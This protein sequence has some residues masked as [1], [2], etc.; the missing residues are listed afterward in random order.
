MAILSL[1]DG[2]TYTELEAI[3]R[4]LASL[5]VQLNCWRLSDDPAAG[6]LIA[7]DSLNDEEKETV[8]KSL[9]GY[10]E[11]LKATDGYQSRDL[12][13]LHPNI[14]NLDNLLAKFISCHTHADDEVRYIID[15]EAVFGFVRP[16]GSQVELT[17]QPE[18][19]INVPAGT[20]HWFHLTDAKRVK[21]VRYFV[22]TEGWIPE[23]TGTEI[24]LGSVN[25]EVQPT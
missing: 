8:L 18:E 17:I 3:A 14:P 5:K 13:V 24:R 10:F 19:Y 16:D 9:D 15:G 1:E 11:Q 6:H 22:T 23:Y 7:Q 4:E 2:T 12:I 21:A 20:E 25:S